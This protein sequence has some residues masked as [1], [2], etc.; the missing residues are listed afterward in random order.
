LQK[1]LSLLQ[2]NYPLIPASTE[3]TAL[4]LLPLLKKILS[5]YSYFYRRK[6]LSLNSCLSCRKFCILFP[7]SPEECL[8]SCLLCRKPCSFFTCP[9]E[10][11]V[12][13]SLSLLGDN[14]PIIPASLQKTLSFLLYYCLS[15]RKYCPS[16]HT[17]TA[18][19]PS[20]LIP[21]SLAENSVFFFLLLLKNAFIPVFFA[22]NSVLFLPVLQKNI[23]LLSLPLLGV[24]YP[25][26]PASLQ[27][28]LSFFT[29]LLPIL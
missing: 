20:P 19:K 14:Y 22:E 12:L 9:S 15:Y 3:N 21:A 5:F 16:I 6:T 7:A 17:S 27:K 13:L 28:T 10:N 18:E 23:V 29:V 2:N 1:T 11:I 24:N 4:L 26:I 25:V 8:Y